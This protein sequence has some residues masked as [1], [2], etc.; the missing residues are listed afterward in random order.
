MALLVIAE[1]DNKTLKG[2]TL[3][4]VAAAAAI[5]G[6]IHLLVAGK[7]AKPAAEAAAKVAGVAKVLLADDAAYEHALAEDVAALAVQ[8]APNYSHVLAPAS[9]FG[10]NV[11]PRVAALLDVAQISDIAGVQSPD[12]FVRPIYADR[13]SVV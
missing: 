7:D 2:A 5:G 9:T 4:A 11:A 10:K 3:N 6:E 8:L 1:H 13:K 12:T